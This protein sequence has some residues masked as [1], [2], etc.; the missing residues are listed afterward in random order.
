MLIICS[1]S[2]FIPLQYLELSVNDDFDMIVFRFI[3]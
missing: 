2:I 1:L 3:F